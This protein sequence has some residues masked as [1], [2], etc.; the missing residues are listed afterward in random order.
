[1]ISALNLKDSLEIKALFELA[2]SVPITEEMIKLQRESWIR[3]MTGEN[4]D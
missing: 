1:M 2:R 4:A 3:G